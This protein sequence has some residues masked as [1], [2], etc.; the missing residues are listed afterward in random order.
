M[1]HIKLKF[2]IVFLLS[3]GLAA[4]DAQPVR[5]VDGNVY[6]AVTIGSQVWMAKNLQTTRY[7]DGT[8]IPLV[9]S[10]PVWD[11]LDENSKAYCWYGDDEKNKNTYGALYTWAAA[12][13]GTE[14]S[15]A[16]PSRVQGICPTGWHLP[17]DT[18]WE[19]L[20]TYLGGSSVAGGKMK[21]TG[22]TNWADPNE[23]ATNE[24]G[25]TGLPGGYRSNGGTFGRFSSYGS[26]WTSTE[27]S[28]T[29]A[30]YRLLNFGNTTIYKLHLSKEVGFSVRC[31]RDY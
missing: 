18:E 1:Q 27:F 31:V 19:E 12:M 29:S 16:N 21:Q 26:W 15:D 5:D 4:T 17:S 20:E 2:S 3:F 13:N 23:G 25:F 9:D 28:P 7:P 10:I 24:S 6:P 8:P 14:S 22:T 30:N 11:V